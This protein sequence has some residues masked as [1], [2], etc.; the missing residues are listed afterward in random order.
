[1][2][3]RVPA[4]R[5]CPATCV[6]LS[7]PC[8]DCILVFKVGLWLHLLGQSRFPEP[9][10]HLS[11]CAVQSL[12]RLSRARQHVL[13]S[14]FERQG[15][16]LGRYTGSIERRVATCTVCAEGSLVLVSEVGS[17]G[18]KNQGQLKPLPIY[19]GV[20]EGPLGVNSRYKKTS[21]GTGRLGGV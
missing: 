11:T 1:M 14:N 16:R 20:W 6:S 18:D 13:S 10:L 8:R 17:I 9:L 4:P 2:K 3:A 21:C 7:G 12:Q 5:T 19:F 15:C